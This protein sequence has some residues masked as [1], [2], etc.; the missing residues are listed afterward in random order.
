MNLC[1][2]NVGLLF[3]ALKKKTSPVFFSYTQQNYII[4]RG[5]INNQSHE[6]VASG[7]QRDQ[8][9]KWFSEL[10]DKGL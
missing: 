5:Q 2:Y 4:D 3:A 1:S 9:T 10:S 7:P 6:K 8:G